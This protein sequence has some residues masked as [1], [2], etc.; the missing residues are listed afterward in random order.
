[1]LY[2]YCICRLSV[3]ESRAHPGS[4]PT[5]STQSPGRPVRQRK[6]KAKWEVDDAEGDYEDEDYGESGAG[7]SLPYCRI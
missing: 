5:H 2:M 1:M 7:V 3:S 4:D 6:E